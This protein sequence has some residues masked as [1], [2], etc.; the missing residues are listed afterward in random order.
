MLLHLA[1]PLQ[2]GL[3]LGHLVTFAEGC[4]YHD[5]F[6][7]CTNQ[8]ELNGVNKMVATTAVSFKALGVALIPAIPLECIT[9]LLS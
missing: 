8:S 2:V 5:L 3:S 7:F 9:D 1:Q 4:C 6:S